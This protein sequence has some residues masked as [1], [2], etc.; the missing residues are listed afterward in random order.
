M[1]DESLL[2]EQETRLLLSVE[3]F[4]VPTFVEEGPSDTIN[5]DVAGL[6]LNPVVGAI[7]AIAAHPT[8]ANKIFIGA[9]AGGIWMTTDGS[10][11]TAL[12]DE[13]PSLSISALA[14]SP[15]DFQQRLQQWRARLRS[16]SQHRWRGYL[17]FDRGGVSG[18]AR[19]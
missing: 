14:F 13:W 17:G 11:W 7:E 10:D 16:S 15:L 8:D 3:L 12:T 5:G 2:V 4:G 18:Q 19:P 9:V 1:F 6:G